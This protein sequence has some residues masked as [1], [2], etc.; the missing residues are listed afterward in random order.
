MSGRLDVSVPLN[1]THDFKLTDRLSVSPA[2]KSTWTPLAFD[3][4]VA[5]P[6]SVTVTLKLA[7]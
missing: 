4:E 2:V 3:N 6:A 7:F 5:P 1:I